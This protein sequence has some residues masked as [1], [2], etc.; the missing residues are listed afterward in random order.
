MKYLE[1]LLV[2]LIGG[3]VVFVGLEAWQTSR[4]SAAQPSGA[5]PI[6]A[7]A[8]PEVTVVGGSVAEREAPAG[9][10]SRAAAARDLE[11]IR[12][13]L[14][15]GEE[16]TYIR[17]ILLARDSA[18]SRWPERTRDPL[19]VWVQRAEGKDGW[20][21]SLPSIVHDAFEQWASVGLPV[22]FVFVV[23]STDAEVRVMWTER[24][25][26]PISGQ[27]NWARN[28]QW[29][30]VDAN[31]TLALHHHNGNPLDTNAI[32]AIALHEIGHLI[33]LDHTSDATS[34]MAPR[35]R[36][37]QISQADRATAHLLY[38]LPAGPV[39]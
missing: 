37:R 13:R 19:R 4:L 8:S 17:E 36:V 25:K 14:R 30:I 1:F 32:R 33:G 16:G 24:F 38:T 21:H 23:D 27:T 34:I 9:R 6:V 5:L 22:R 28:E 7:A 3:L 39:R 15:V 2:G 10:R 35:V 26:D 11:E 29:W 20:T 31:I 12:R 18:L